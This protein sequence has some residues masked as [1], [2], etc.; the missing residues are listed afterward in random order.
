VSGFKDA[1]ESQPAPEQVCFPYFFAMLTFMS[2]GTPH[3]EGY[4]NCNQ[5][6]LSL[7][8]LL[9]MHD[10]PCD[11]PW[12]TKN[13]SMSPGADVSCICQVV[14]AEAVTGRIVDQLAPFGTE[15]ALSEA[16]DADMEDDGEQQ[17]AQG[18][19]AES[20]DAHAAGEAQ[21]AGGQAGSGNKQM[22][23]IKPAHSFSS[24]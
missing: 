6:L 14:E 10:L 11:L 3:C 17:D 15:P 24:P 5:R 19:A 21:A 9:C 13:G 2:I 22:V 1:N 16:V 7:C 8:S 12:S 20:P 23:S 4:H 18:G